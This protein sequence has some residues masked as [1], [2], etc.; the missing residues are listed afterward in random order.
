[1]GAGCVA[2]LDL[3]WAP[4]VSA[5]PLGDVNVSGAS[6]TE[7]GGTGATGKIVASNGCTAD[8]RLD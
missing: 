4:H 2:A 7:T 5:E 3:L 8:C 6:P 1:M